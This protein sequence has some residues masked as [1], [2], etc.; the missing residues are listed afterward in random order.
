MVP[1]GSEAV[2]I[3]AVRMTAVADMQR[4]SKLLT[5]RIII[6]S[7]GMVGIIDKDERS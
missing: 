6:I 2:S 4:L 3:F 7:L 1:Q 5:G